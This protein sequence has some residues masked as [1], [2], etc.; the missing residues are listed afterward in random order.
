MDARTINAFVSLNLKHPKLGQETG[1]WCFI[2]ILSR[3]SSVW[4]PHM[5]QPLL[6]SI[7]T[8][9]W[10]IWGRGR[11]GDKRRG[12]LDLT[13]QSERYNLWCWRNGGKGWWYCKV[14]LC[15]ILRQDPLSMLPIYPPAEAS[16]SFLNWSHG[17]GKLIDCNHLWIHIPLI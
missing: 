3:N 1:H 16:Y 13:I 2:K 15:T 8:C 14:L 4:S 10:V 7:H 12:N 17:R 6:K 9:M 5:P 11:H